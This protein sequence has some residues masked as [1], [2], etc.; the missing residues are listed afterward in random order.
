MGESGVNIYQV[1]GEKQQNDRK[2]VYDRF[3]F[4]TTLPDTWG[5]KRRFILLPINKW[6]TAASV[7]F[8]ETTCDSQDYYNAERMPTPYLCQAMRT[9]ALYIGFFNTGAYQESI[10][11]FG[12]VQ[13][14]LIPA[15]NGNLEKKT[16]NTIRNSF[17][18]SRHTNPCLKF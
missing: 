5:I 8:W 4:Q 3:L 15:P 17:P 6:T 7:S 18:R 11:G 16:V 2:V 9:G 14:C 13:H 1:L 10:S 12:G